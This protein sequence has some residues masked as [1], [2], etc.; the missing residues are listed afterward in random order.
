MIALLRV[1]L[2]RLRWR[3]AVLALLALGVVVPAVVFVGT[4]ISSQSKT[5]DELAEQYGQQ[6][7]TQVEDCTAQPREHGVDPGGDTQK[8]C[9]RLIQGYYGEAPLDLR[10]EREN[11][12]GPALVALLTL[13]ML[14]VGTTFAGHD[15][16]TGSM[17]NQLLFEPRRH[18][19]WLAKLLAVGAVAAGLATLML[20]AHWTGLYA[21]S[22]A[23]DLVQP[24][25]SVVAAYKQ[26]VLGVLLVA[27]AGVLGYALTMLL[28]STV[29]TLGVMFATGFAGVVVVAAGVDSA[30][31]VMPWGNFIAWVVGRYDY[32]VY[33][34][35]FTAE[36][37][38]VRHIERSDS[39][40][41]F[42]V[43]LV[44]VVT[45]SLV[46]FRQRDVP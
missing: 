16:N 6:V 30:E 44:V 17:S 19:V 25:H 5:L 46:S 34:D 20:L 8:D 38:P 15:W 28:R 21:V 39:A 4:A 10:S 7:L 2:T 29:A 33:E 3:R 23:R 32:Y 41:Y 9:E 24:E 36:C 26:V 13:V 35:C 45:A 14:L 1:E 12:S 42:L 31:R 18:R 27:A 22:S 37:V 43:L 40:V 11:A